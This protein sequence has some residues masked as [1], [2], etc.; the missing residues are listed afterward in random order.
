[1]L[2]VSSSDATC[3][4]TNNIVDC[5]CNTGNMN[6]YGS[7]VAN[8]NYVRS[9]IGD[10]GCPG[11]IKDTPHAS[12]CGEEPINYNDKV[13]IYYGFNQWLAL[14]DN[15]PNTRLVRK[16]EGNRT[17][18]YIRHIPK[19]SNN[20][21]GDSAILNDPDN[22]AKIMIAKSTDSAHTNCGWYGCRVL[23]RRS[24]KGAR[25]GH[26][27]GDFEGGNINDD[28]KLV[29]QKHSIGID[30]SP[31]NIIRNKDYVK[32]QQGEGRF[33]RGKS[34]KNWLDFDGTEWGGKNFQIYKV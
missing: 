5:D 27:K 21:G 20:L 26:G 12:G 16:G 22:R 15:N 19:L 14:D 28:K 1:M 6:N 11:D 8:S 24:D 18:F 23:F 29:I 7:C 30:S 10:S 33:L 13:F 2:D 17:G 25:F 3:P 31:G 32:I 34:G 9:W 4:E